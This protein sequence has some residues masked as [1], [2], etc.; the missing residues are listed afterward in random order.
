MSEVFEINKQIAI[1]LGWQLKCN[2]SDWYRGHAPGTQF[3]LRDHHKWQHGLMWDSADRAWANARMEW[4]T[5][6]DVMIK[7][8]GNKKFKLTQRA[9]R[10]TATIATYYHGEGA[11]AALATCRAWLEWYKSTQ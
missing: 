8:I 9:E 7:L 5:S 11:T 4:A 3:W 2:D 10:W 1:H 6:V